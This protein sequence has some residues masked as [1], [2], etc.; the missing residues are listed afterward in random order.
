M[1]SIS[2]NGT[3]TLVR[4]GKVAGALNFRNRTAGGSRR[5]GEELLDT[6]A[7]VIKHRTR[8]QGLSPDGAPL[9]PLSRAYLAKKFREGH[10]GRILVRTGEMTDTQELLGE[11]SVGSNAASMTGGL[12]EETRDKIEWA[13]EGSPNRPKRPFYDLGQDGQRAIEGVLDEAIDRAVRQP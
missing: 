5:L 2:S 3:E 11:T 9:A 1:A 8:D 4:L 12:D 7:T 6:T 13:E 10:D